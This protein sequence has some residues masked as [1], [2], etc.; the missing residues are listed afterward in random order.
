MS[1]EACSLAGHLGLGR[2]I[3]LYDANQ[4]TI[5]GRIDIAFTEDVG[6]RFRAYG[7]HVAEVRDADS[8]LDGV[9]GAIKAA[10][11]VTDRPSLILLHT[12]N[13]YGSNR[14][15]THKVGHL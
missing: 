8:D 14:Q 15:G 3:L 11:D 4:T 6:A 7:W 12:T 1:S 5:D 2:L 10:Q 13:G 9:E